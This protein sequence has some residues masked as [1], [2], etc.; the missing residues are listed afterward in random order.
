MSSI[1]AAEINK[2][3]VVVDRVLFGKEMTQFMSFAACAKPGFRV[4]S[5]VAQIG[6]SAFDACRELETVSI[7]E[8]VSSIGLSAFYERLGL[9][10]ITIP[11]SVASIAIIAFTKY[12]KL[13]NISVPRRHTYPSD[14]FPN[15]A[16]ISR[17]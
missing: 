8:S 10:S 16:T 3:F 13:R 14:A 4:P 2:H 5:I 11:R 7:P 15:R 1:E 17:Y 12:F 9:T 6:H